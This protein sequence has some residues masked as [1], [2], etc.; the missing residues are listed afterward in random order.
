MKKRSL[1]GAEKQLKR[2]RGKIKV[3]TMFMYELLKLY[4]KKRYISQ[5]N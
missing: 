5:Y 1:N 3:D 2:R 4:I